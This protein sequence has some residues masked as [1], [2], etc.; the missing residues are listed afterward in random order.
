MVMV[1]LSI[2]AIFKTFSLQPSMVHTLSAGLLETVGQNADSVLKCWKER[3]QDIAEALAG[4]TATESAVNEKVDLLLASINN[5]M[6]DQCATNGAF[7]RLLLDVRS[8][9]L[10]KVVENWD[11]LSDLEKSKLNNLND[12]FCKVHPLLSFSQEA[13]K[14]LLQFENAI[15]EGKSKYALPTNSES[16]TFRLITR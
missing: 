1:R 9:V 7:N 5:T 6:S 11:N 12:F 8:D 16:G 15:L 13:N 10:P 3:V 14:A 2:I 4:R